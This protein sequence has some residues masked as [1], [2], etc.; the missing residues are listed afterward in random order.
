[1][2]Q[3]FGQQR[4]AE[5][6]ADERRRP[7]GLYRA[8]EVCQRGGAVHQRHSSARQQ[9]QPA[10]NACQVLERVPHAHDRECHRVGRVAVLLR[11]QARAGHGI[12]GGHR[13]DRF[14][15]GKVVL[16]RNAHQNKQHK[17]QHQQAGA[18][19]A[20]FAVPHKH[21]QHP[22][23]GQQQQAF[24]AK[25]VPIRRGI[26]ATIQQADGQR[27]PQVGDGARQRGADGQRRDRHSGR[28]KCQHQLR[29]RQAERRNR[30]AHD[31]HG[32]SQQGAAPSG[33]PSRQPAAHRREQQT[34]SVNQ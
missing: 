2:F 9:R 32:Q 13:L 30:A 7:Q 1:M 14:T 27:Q 24:A 23:G 12:R 4:Q 25:L 22:A 28:Q 29:Q 34:E 11:G 15:V 6:K 18:G 17:Q 20:Q 19:V 16:E 26:P 5:S 8:G 21:R 33:A 10:N 3:G 31:P